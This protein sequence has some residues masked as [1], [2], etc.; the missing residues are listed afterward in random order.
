MNCDKQFK[1]WFELFNSVLKT[2][3]MAFS[4]GL[5]VWTLFWTYMNSEP[6]QF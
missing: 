6:S 1:I 2:K 4:D 3:L 5:F